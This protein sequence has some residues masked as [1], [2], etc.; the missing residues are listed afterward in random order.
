MSAKLTPAAATW[1]RTSPRPGLGTGASL[2]KRA[3]RGP[4]SEVCCRAR[5]VTGMLTTIHSLFSG[6]LIA[7]GPVGEPTLR[8]VDR[9]EGRKESAGTPLDVAGVPGRL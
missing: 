4:C 9:R 7:A 1:I 8:D 6:C 3:S 2:I 5:I